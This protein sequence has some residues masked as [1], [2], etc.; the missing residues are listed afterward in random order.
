[1]YQDGVDVAVF[2]SSMACAADCVAAAL[3]PVPLQIC[4]NMGNMPMQLRGIDAVAYNVRSTYEKEKSQWLAMGIEPFLIPKGTDVDEA[5]A[6]QV[7]RQE[8]GLS[9][10]VFLLVTAANHL[11][12]R[13]SEQ[14]LEVVAE[15]LLR[16]SHTHYLVV[17]VG[18]FTRQRTFFAKKGLQ[19]R[20]TFFGGSDNV[21]ALLKATDVYLNEFPRGG[22]MSVLEAMAAGCP[23][24]AMKFSNEHLE[25]CGVEWAGEEYG[26]M[27]R[28]IPAY[29]NLAFRLIE[30]E[31]FRKQVGAAMRRRYETDLS[32]RKMVEKFESEILRLAAKR[33]SPSSAPSE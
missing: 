9:E 12:R 17:G 15:I 2:H 33:T 8:L 3:K 21:P 25:S 30:D 31:Q 5:A 27:R 23:V 29:K 1:L 22:G 28:D 32:P 10:N 6:E 13:L 11:P 20:V 26:I 19:E 14:F 4:N 16:Y 18:D 24:V 7:A